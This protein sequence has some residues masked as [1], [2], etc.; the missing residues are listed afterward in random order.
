ML[1][2]RY[3]GGAAGNC[4]GDVPYVGGGRAGAICGDSPW[5][6]GGG[7]GGCGAN[8]IGGERAAML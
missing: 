7:I 5:A 6:I 1:P 2:A 8:K 3:A 4:C